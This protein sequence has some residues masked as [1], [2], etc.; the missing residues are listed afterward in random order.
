MSLD[1]QWFHLLTGLLIIVIISCEKAPTEQNK[2]NDNISNRQFESIPSTFK[3]II[4]SVPENV[5]EKV[6]DLAAEKAIKLGCDGIRILQVETEKIIKY[7]LLFFIDE[8][9]YDA[10]ECFMTPEGTTEEILPDERNYI[11]TIWENQQ[12]KLKKTNDGIHQCMLL[13]E[14][15][16]GTNYTGDM[17]RVTQ[18]AHLTTG[19]FHK[20]IYCLDLSTCLIQCD[21]TTFPGNFHDCISSHKW[22]SF[23]SEW[24]YYTWPDILKVW[25]SS[26]FV[27]AA[28]IFRDV[29][30]ASCAARDADWADNGDAN[31]NARSLRL[32]YYIFYN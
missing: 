17:F 24:G 15:Y 21:G 25:K 4:L 19:Y 7:H 2:N 5:P 27:D 31:N 9:G 23:M 29:Y 1:K 12:N 3:D 10:Y 20:L 22:D 6:N 8:T 30:G 18:A 16:K 28:W 32:Q 14:F 13:A 26:N 11:N